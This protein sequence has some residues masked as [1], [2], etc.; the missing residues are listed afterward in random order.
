MPFPGPIPTAEG[1][2]LDLSAGGLSMVIQAPG[3]RREEVQSF[4]K[5]AR[6]VCL[7]EAGS[8]AVPVCVVIVDWPRTLGPMDMTFDARRVRTEVL[9]D[10]LDTSE[11][12]KNA[13]QV[14]LLDGQMVRGLK[15]MGLPTALMEGMQGIV[16]RQLSTNYTQGQ[17]DQALATIYREST[18]QLMARATCYR[19]KEGYR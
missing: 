19:H 4:K 8:A 6:Q 16:R 9:T 11:G 3:L 14:I 15:L 7:L 5:G 17:F 1:A 18:P 13:L 2:T 10:W 12:V